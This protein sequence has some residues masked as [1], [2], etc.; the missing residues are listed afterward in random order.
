MPTRTHLIIG[1]APGSELVVQGNGVA[2]RHAQLT[3]REGLIL[4]DLG[5][6]RTTV[7]G[8]VLGPNEQ[9][10]LAGFHATV[11]IGDARVPLI[12]AEITKL[13]VDRSN[14]PPERAG[15]VVVG[16]DPARA[17]VVVSHPTVSGAHLRVDVST[18][19]V[20]DLGSKSGTFDRNSQRLP[21]NTPV[22]I[23][24][25][26]GYSLGAVWIPSQAL[27]ELAGAPVGA[28][29]APQM[30]PAP[31]DLGGRGQAPAGFAPQAGGGFASHQG[32]PQGGHQGGHQGAPQGGPQGFGGAPQGGFGSQQ[33]YGPPAGAAM[34]SLQGQAPQGHGAAPA[35]AQPNRTMFGTFDLSGGGKA[36]AMIGRL[37]T[38][39]IVLPYPQVSSRHTSVMKSPDG[40]LLIGDLGSTNGTYVNGQRLVPGQPLPVPPKSKIFVGPYPV[41]VDLQGNSITAYVEQENQQFQSANLVEI[42]ALD[43]EL[44]V[45]DREDKT[46]DKILLNHVTFKALPGD[47]IALMGPSGAGKT[48][49]LTVLNGYLRPTSGEVR[50][51]G[52]N[53][54]A[55]YDALRGSIGYVPQDDI[56]HPELTVKEA[57]TYSARFRL[58]ADYSDE[59]IEKRVEQTILD[60]SLGG[61]KNLEIGKPEK[62]V[63]S[64]GQRKRVNIA[65]ELVTDPAL[66]FLDEPTSGLAADDTVALID[67]L[68]SLAKKYGKT[69]I[70]TIHQPAREEYEKFNLAFI[71]GYGGEPVFFGPT[72]KKSYDFFAQYKGQPIDNPRDMFD[73]LKVREEDMLRQMPQGTKKE[74]ARLAAAQEWRK[75]FYR[76]D[77]ATYREMYSGKREPGKPGQ[78]RPPSRATVPLI[79]QFALL[80]SRYTIVKRRDVAGMIIMLAQA[81]IIGGLLAAVFFSKEAQSPNLWCQNQLMTLEREAQASQ[82]FMQC[83]AGL[84]QTPEG[85]T[86]FAKVNDF[87]GAIF[88]LTVGSLWFGVS[89]AAREIVAEIA[90]YRRE[91]MVNLSIFNYLMS[92]FVLLTM[93]CV[94]Q[95]TVL[96]GIVYTSLNLGHNTWDAFLPMLGTMILSA[97]CAVSLGLLISTAVTSSEAAMALT[98][99]ALIPQVVLGGLLVP[100]TNKTWL[101]VAMAVM[102]ARWSFEGV[103]GAERD[104]VATSW[105]IPTCLDAGR[106]VLRATDA[107][108]R[109]LYNC[110]VEEIASTVANSGGFGF[111]TWDQPLVH[112]GILAGMTVLFLTS[113]AV[114]LKRR[115]SV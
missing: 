62:K 40:N 1:S 80:F 28:T 66:M 55:I 89:N 3:W 65:L 69:I 9:V 77:N 21:A 35:G 111:G 96:L 76:P 54:Y 100:M 47:L 56:L 74:A 32:G 72:G 60:L 5:A 86:R 12:S 98:P 24:M 105:R 2:P 43:L 10:Q 84:N 94:V 113:V 11:L 48:T 39:D 7:D 17:N 91:R 75:V 85:A 87:K 112:N 38:C 110:A 16:R 108:G 104:A 42:E 27:L 4:Q 34:A 106:G 23:D 95:C 31:T 101:K 103:M 99:I 15:L 78:S 29:V 92:K 26:G 8:R 61:V 49:L 53:L 51:N 107:Q 82:A 109:H 114:L 59:E 33:G 46:R 6:G 90:I 37:P 19:T 25:A 45:P 115:D 36:I 81:P 44:K 71:M 63:L 83:A 93:L 70:V 97:M 22:S 88:F 52:E 102:P 73:Q 20:T 57:I 13:F 67:L 79:R 18:R 50:I 14:L 58:P 30:A 41:V 68:S 64:G